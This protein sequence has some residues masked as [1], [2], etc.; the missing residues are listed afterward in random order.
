MAETITNTPQPKTLSF[1]NFLLDKGYIT[2]DALTQAR[3]ESVTTHRNLFDYLVGEKYISEEELTQA[4]GLFFNLP[5]VDLRNKKVEKEVL[6]LISK[7]TLATYKFLPFEFTGDVLKVALTDPTNLAALG[8]L[9]FVAQKKNA[10][11]EL[12]ITSLTGF[13]TLFR[14]SENITTEVKQA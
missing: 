12:Y 7:E 8:A 13:Q 4:R 2:K 1:E 3:S 11:L 9:E 6:T 14:K 5:Y 10:R